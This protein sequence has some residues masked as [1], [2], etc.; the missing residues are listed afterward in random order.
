MATQGSPLQNQFD[1]DR[2]RATRRTRRS[3]HVYAT[4]VDSHTGARARA[5]TQTHTADQRVPT[6]E[7]T[8]GSAHHPTTKAMS[9]KPH[10]PKSQ[11]EAEE[12]EARR[13]GRTPNGSQVGG[14]RQTLNPKPQPLTPKRLTGSRDRNTPSPQTRKKEILEPTPPVTAS[15]RRRC[16]GSWRRRGGAASGARRG[17]PHTWPGRAAAACARTG[18][19]GPAAPPRA[20]PTQSRAPRPPASASPPASNANT[21]EAPPPASPRNPHAKS[22]PLGHHASTTPRYTL[23]RARARAG[24][25]SRARPRRSGAGRRCALDGAFG[26]PGIT[27]CAE[28]SARAL[29]I[30]ACGGSPAPCGRAGASALHAGGYPCV[31]GGRRV[32]RCIW[33]AA[34]CGGGGAW[35]AASAPRRR[36]TRRPVHRVRRRAVGLLGHLP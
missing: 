18:P 36:R 9:F 7:G 30:H 25:E 35:R 28:G 16:G 15:A 26:A 20:R 12:E 33:R 3:A 2:P 32:R 5:H 21:H 34:A 22:G 17:R 8:K 10:S 4:D 11:T 31:Q 23:A 13:K 19:P 14:F 1:Q 6:A 29:G 27:G 24:M